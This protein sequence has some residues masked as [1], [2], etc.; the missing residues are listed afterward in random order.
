MSTPS[1]A[2]A[3]HPSRAGTTRSRKPPRPLLLIG[4]LVGLSWIF[5]QRSIDPGTIVV[6]V[7]LGFGL[8]WLT[9]RFWPGETR[10]A[11]PLTALK[12][13]FT[14]L[15]DIIISSLVVARQIVRSPDRLQPAFIELP[16]D[17]S[18]DLA[19]SLLASC[20]SLT[21]GTVSVEISAD[22]KFLRAHGLH[23][24]DAQETISSV[25]ARYEQPL[26]EIFQC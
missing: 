21:P 9:R 2:P 1:Q 7:I 26:K 6:A 20:I 5:L 16:L 11:A 3:P 17:L 14:L 13:F 24:P 12:L 10:V 22:R 8:P 4:T 19:I 23:V 25:K 18:D 15:W